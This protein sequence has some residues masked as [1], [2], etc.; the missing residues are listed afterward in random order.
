MIDCIG[1]SEASIWLHFCGFYSVPDPVDQ[2]R[3]LVQ[4]QQKRQHSQSGGSTPYFAPNIIKIYVLV[5]ESSSGITEMKAQN[6]FT[7]VQFILSSTIPKYHIGS[8]VQG[9]I[10]FGIASGP[11]NLR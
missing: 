8:M 5:H 10:L 6:I 9:R 4:N 7:Q 11:G 2:F 1:V 3:T